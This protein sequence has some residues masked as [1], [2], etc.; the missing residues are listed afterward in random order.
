[1]I[2]ELVIA[3][4]NS[5][6]IKE[7]AKLLEQYNV[8]V[9]SQKD[10]S[11]DDIEETGKTFIEN[12]IIKAR[13]VSKIAKLP[14]LGDDSGLVV[15]A[16]NGEPGLYSARYS[17]ANS[18]D[19]TNCQK[20]LTNMQGIENRKASFVCVLA[21]CLSENHPLPII[22]QGKWDGEIA[23]KTIG[24]N[25]FGY[26][27]VFFIPSLNKTSAQLEKSEKNKISHRSLA[28]NNLLK[29]TLINTKK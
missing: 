12:A 3:S 11:I 8:K 15:P 13:H 6:K 24:D 25:G 27:P 7:I 2:K 19:K 14:A 26:D 20:L 10:F 9:Y 21:L 4:N 23:K 22:A 28:F 29:E 5:G 17:G 16:L 18:N 1:M